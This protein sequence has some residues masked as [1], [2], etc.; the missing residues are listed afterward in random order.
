MT[1][2]FPYLEKS[3]AYLGLFMTLV[4]W[5][6]EVDIVVNVRGL[7]LTSTNVNE[8]SLCQPTARRQ[9]WALY[10]K[11]TSGCLTCDMRSRT[12]WPP[13]QGS[14]TW[15]LDP[16]WSLFAH[17][18]WFKMGS[19]GVP[20]VVPQVRDLATLHQFGSLLRHRFNPQPRHS[21]LRIHHCCSCRIGL[22]CSSDSVPGPG[23]LALAQPKQ[24]KKYNRDIPGLTQISNLLI[25]WGP[26]IGWG[27]EAWKRGEQ[28]ERNLHGHSFVLSPS[29]RAGPEL[30]HTVLHRGTLDE[31][32]SSLTGSSCACASGFRDS[33]IHL[34]S[35]RMRKRATTLAATT[36]TLTLAT[37]TTGLTGKLGPLGCLW[38]QVW[39]FYF[40][41]WFFKAWV[42]PTR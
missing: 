24:K 22:S 30:L 21:G 23:T 11:K 39:E 40:T 42:S 33:T 27:E 38:P 29:S 14:L 36:P 6:N 37:Q 13:V 8:T 7:S 32:Q 18:W 28:E 9:E 41:V 16:G 20:T 3:L 2:A 31:R 15:V 35:F 25:F 5:L 1:I 26:K 4:E 19:I 17:K 12:F 10:I 34:V